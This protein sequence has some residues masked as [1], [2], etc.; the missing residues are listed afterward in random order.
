MFASVRNPKDTIIHSGL[1]L[2]LVL[3]L[4]LAHL[5]EFLVLLL[6]SF[7]LLQRPPHITRCQSISTSGDRLVSCDKPLTRLVSKA[8]HPGCTGALPPRLCSRHPG[9]FPMG[10]HYGLLRALYQKFHRFSG[11]S[12][13][14]SFHPERFLSALTPVLSVRL[15]VDVTRLSLQFPPLQ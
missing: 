12:K 14:F 13:V 6:E 7:Q 10:R 5:L 2:N 1:V 3:N 9:L 4:S 11:S 15:C 8:E